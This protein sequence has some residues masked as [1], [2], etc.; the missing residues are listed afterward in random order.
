METEV[1]DSGQQAYPVR[2]CTSTSKQ[3]AEVRQRLDQAEYQPLQLLQ[4]AEMAAEDQAAG[5]QA[6]P[7]WDC[8][9]AS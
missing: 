2:H 6:Y 8:P 9:S 4:V 7:V 3:R 1:L 5:E